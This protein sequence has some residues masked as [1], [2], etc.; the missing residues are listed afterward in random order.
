MKM[1]C[2]R[3]PRQ[4][5]F[6]TA[7]GLARLLQVFWMFPL[8]LRTFVQR[9]FLP[10]RHSLSPIIFGVAVLTALASGVANGQESRGAADLG[11]HVESKF[12]P[13]P[14]NARAQ[15]Q[16]RLP[17]SRLPA[18][19]FLD[20]VDAT[21]LSMEAAVQP[22]KPGVPLKIGFSRDVPMLRTTS[23]T[24]ALMVWTGVSG[25]QIAVI[26]IT[27]PDAMGV[28]LGLL[29][30]KLPATA[31]LR[32]YAQG[33]DQVF[34]VLG[35][36]IMDTIARNLAAGDK[37]DEARTYWSPVI[38][39]QEI[40]V[41][42]ELPAGVSADDVRFSIPRVSHLFSSPL[43]TRALQEKIGQA[44]SCNLDSMCYQST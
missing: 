22:S 20:R 40:T 14:A 18:P 31:L 11:P 1:N 13:A 10:G 33:T 16:R 8:A 35:Q 21:R 37:S 5:L 7:S 6:Q 3:S 15:A 24:S 44:A 42:I 32:F 28:R 39:G 25:G 23:Q 38:D 30:E 34:E 19:V 29:V 4:S 2:A 43:D 41:E 17:Q 36:E 12:A 27:S 9:G 26:S